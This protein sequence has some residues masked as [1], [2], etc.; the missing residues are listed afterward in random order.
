MQG[1]GS[2]WSKTLTLPDGRKMG[3]VDAGNAEGFPLFIIHGLP[4]SR[5]DALYIGEHISRSQEIRFIV[6][7][8]PGIGLSDFH[9][10]RR[11][12]DYPADITALADILGLDEFSVF[13]I[14]AGGP[15]AFA[16]ALK[17]PERLHAVGIASSIAPLDLP[18]IMQNMGVGRYFFI[19][20]RRLPWLVHLQFRMMKYGLRKN[21]SKVIEQVKATFPVP[22]QE[23]FVQEHMQQAFLASVEEMIRQ[24][25][26]G[27]VYEAGLLARPW[28]F[29]VDEIQMPVKIWYGGQ[30]TNTPP[31]MGRYFAEHVPNV[32]AH[33]MPEEG[34]FS[35]ITRNIGEMIRAITPQST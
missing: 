7:D 34:H 1:L 15:F 3:Y 20:A 9:P 14:S 5:L 35:I 23:V 31:Q 25:T 29:S 6:P 17:I 30:D 11:I 32:E 26:D 12:L 33:F 2:N 28:G 4:G 21:P 22:D 10:N 27:M 24:G 16:C 19:N 8:R 13:G 18:G